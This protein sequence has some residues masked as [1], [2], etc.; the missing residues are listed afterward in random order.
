MKSTPSAPYI[1]FAIRF[2]LFSD[3]ERIVVGE[4]EVALIFFDE[5]HDFFRQSHAAFAAFAPDFRQFYVYADL[6]ALIFDKL[7]FRF[8]YR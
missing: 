8:S 4:C 2:D 6:F 3:G 5:T 7:Q 1:F